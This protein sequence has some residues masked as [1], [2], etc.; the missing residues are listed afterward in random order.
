MKN[1]YEVKF[2]RRR[3]GKT[4]YKKRLALLKS[5]KSRLVVRRKNKMMIAQV[6]AYEPEG[7]K[8]LVNTTSL[9]L[10]KYGYA[11]HLGNVCAAYLTGFLCGRKALKKGISEAILDIG[12][13]SPVSGSN[14]FAALSGAVD[15]GMKIPYSDD[16][17]PEKERTS[18]KKIE[19]YR[20]VSLN[21]DK[22]KK[23]IEAKI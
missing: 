13:H 1:A 15:A 2:K 12:R 7:D 22:V 21:V 8:T 9:E 19:E 10:K 18:G 17:L 23:E 3:E 16:I 20:K 11:G 4:D 5:G 14:V 6:M